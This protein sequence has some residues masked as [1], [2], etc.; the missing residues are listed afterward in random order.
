MEER[1]EPIFAEAATATLGPPLSRAVIVVAL[2]DVA[3]HLLLSTRYGYFRDELY[4]LACANHLD[5]GYVDHPPLSIL[6]LWLETALFG[7]SLPA[8]RLVPALAGGAL[9]FLT[10]AFARE[11]GGGRW[12]QI[13]AAVSVFVGPGMLGINGFYSMNAIEPLFFIGAAW[14]VVTIIKTGRERLWLWFGVLA[15]LGLENKLSMAFLCFGIAVGLLL[16]ENRKYLLSRWLWLGAA[17]AAAIYLPHVIWQA[18]NGFPTL[19]F[20]ANAQATKNYHA[21]LPEFL[22]QQLLIM[23][24]LTAPVWLAGLWYYFATDDGR[25]FRVLGW[26]FVAILAVFILQGAKAYYLVPAYPMLFAPGAAT[27]ERWGR[28]RAWNWLV[29]ATVGVIAIAGA[30]VAPMAMPIL[31][32]P[33]LIRYAAA[34]GASE[35]VRMERGKVGVLPQHFADMFGWTEKVEAVA[36]VYQSLSPQDRAVTAIYAQNYGEAGAIDFFGPRYG[37]PRA[38]SGHNSYWLWGPGE[39][40]ARNLIVIGGDRKDLDQ[41]CTEATVAAVVH[42]SLCMPF[43]DNLPI[44]L[45]RGLKLPVR[46]IW[47]RAKNYQ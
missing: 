13:L 23:H 9:V 33:L 22:A 10:G 21:A 20:I 43:E 46:Q 47:P 3:L 39:L 40:P 5:F 29:P 35:G 42:C 19:E 11:F 37:L 4:Y 27:I 6:I 30:A 14:I 15:G 28:E 8:L 2:A 32:V 25:R 12:A 31:P 17:I 16:T 45:C 1:T 26:T 41:F 7:T 34:L 44:Y 38:I 18:M 36:R 24:P